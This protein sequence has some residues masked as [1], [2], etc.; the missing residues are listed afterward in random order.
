MFVPSVEL[1]SITP[2][3]EIKIVR[4][5]RVSSNNQNSDGIGLIKYLIKHKHW[6]PF[7]MA[8]MTLKITTTRD[9]SRQLIR[10]RSFSFQEFSQRYQTNAM[11]Q[12]SPCLKKARL[13]DIK[14]RQNSLSTDDETL[15]SDWCE[16]QTKVWNTCVE[17]YNQ[18]LSKGI[19]KEQARCLLPEG[20]TKTI[21]YMSGTIR[22]WIH[23][24]DTRSGNDTQEEHRLVVERV[25]QI[26]ND[27]LPVC[28]A[29][30]GT[31]E[32]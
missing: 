12:D 23:Y 18:A 2:N 26:F 7:E 21:V 15:K 27:N 24:M 19:A 31:T 22:S 29:A 13:Q 6:S 8:T 28:S 10:H 16:I 9:I 30:I 1:E 17:Y 4:M 14:N 32:F 20:M 5:A 3:A 25:R 11:I